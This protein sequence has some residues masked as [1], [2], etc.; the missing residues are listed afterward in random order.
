[1][2]QR[3]T[4]NKVRAGKYLCIH[5]FVRSE[6]ICTSVHLLL[7]LLVPHLH[8]KGTAVTVA[9]YI[10]SA[11]IGLSQ[12]DANTHRHTEASLLNISRYYLQWLHVTWRNK[13]KA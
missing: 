5:S 6:E 3:Q 8:I 9:T 12:Q 13:M 11:D 1:M 10:C 4:A 7:G 2:R